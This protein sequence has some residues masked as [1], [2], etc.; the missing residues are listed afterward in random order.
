MITTRRLRLI[1]LPL[2]FAT[3]S[4][5]ASAETIVVHKTPWCGCCTKWVE[6]LQAAG[7]TVE[8]HEHENLT[9]VARELGVP[10]ALRSCHTATVAGYAI[11]GHVPA[12]DIRRLLKE[13]PQAAGLSVPGM[14]IGS[15]GMEQGDMREPYASVL[16]TRDGEMS[17]FARH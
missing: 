16:F 14:P 6:H 8:V 4:C 12:A 13:K 5:M 9:P 2:L 15:P 11:E 1:L 7:F 17:I 10:D 3:W